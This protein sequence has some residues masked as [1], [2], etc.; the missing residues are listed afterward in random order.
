MKILYLTQSQIPSRSANSIHVM[1]LANELVKYGNEVHV[2]SQN[3]KTDI[4]KVK[5]IYKYY[6]VKKSNL[7]K[8][9]ICNLSTNGLLREAFYFIKV[10]FLLIKNKYDIIYSRNIYASYLLSLMGI[11]SMMEL[12]SPP[13]KY[14]KF[15][16]KKA[17]K[18]KSVKCIITI[19]ESLEKFIKKN[20]SLKE[21]P[22]K[23]IRDAA[24][25]FLVNNISYL[26]KKFKIK[27]NS[28]GYIGGLFRGRGIDLIID[29]AFKCKDHNFYIVG[30]TQNE[31]KFWKARVKSD[32]V[33]F[34]GYLEH[35]KSSQLSFVF[36]ILIA[37][38]QEKVYV[39]GSTLENFEKNA[40][41][42]SKFMSPLKIFEYMATKKPIITSDMPVLREFLN[43]NENCILCNSKKIDE[44]ISAIKKLKSN[45][46]F[47]KR[48]TDNAYNELVNN[49][50]W[51]KRAKNII[52]FNQVSN[53]I[54]IFN[55]NLDG[56][57]AENV[58]T[59]ISNNL[60]L[61]KPNVMLALANKRGEYIN[62]VNKNVKI[63]N[64]KK[65]R[66]LFCFF[67]LMFLI[68]KY[69]PDYLFSTIV[70]SNLISIL[71]KKI[72]F[73]SN[74]KVIIRESNHLSKKLN[75][76]IFSNRIL[77]F[78]A[79]LLYKRSN[80]IISPTRVIFNDLKNNFNVPKHK[81][82]VIN[83]PVEIKEILKLS[84][85]KLR[86]NLPK[87]YLISIGR[88]TYQKNYD[89]L[90]DSYYHF[91][92]KN[93]N[94][95]LIILGQGPDKVAITEK[96]NKLNLKKKVILLG[97]KKNPFNYLKKSKLLIL[98]SRW[99]GYPNVLVQGMTLNKKIIATDCFGS[100]KEVLGN[101]GTIFKTKNPILFAEG[102]N[103]IYK[104]KKILNKYKQVNQ[105]KNNIDKFM[106][107]F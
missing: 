72:L 15:F 103:Q 62:F 12:H 42:T 38:Y 88:L 10:L 91:Q 61:K 7:L 85:I 24:N 49:Y 105:I 84:K 64:F 86:K 32:N 18:N 16:F 39:H 83:N 26:K 102:I 60:C 33:F 28:V 35:Y 8:V 75:N 21:I 11:K 78:S 96:I 31:I 51:S 27:K 48:I 1:S 46:D 44:W 41:E 63:I 29:I 19:S 36:D 70:N 106:E 45:N 89:F 97:Y 52:N 90:I 30:G 20:F 93:K 40:L 66:T 76:N 82:E 87:N 22:I 17:L 58:I 59:I 13:Q 101:S 71:L 81:I 92:K 79:K 37:P 95:Y 98:S 99:E 80:I 9:I 77:R 2:V 73:L 14:A 4:F 57:G 25:V 34:I 69:R 6:N 68:L 43:N 100:S 54:L 56:G 47:K 3:N 5:N 107:L 65:N 55:A 74:F 53:K 50:T 67:N 94:C 23:V 104:S